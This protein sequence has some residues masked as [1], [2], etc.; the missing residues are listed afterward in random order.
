[1]KKIFVSFLTK[2]KSFYCL[3]KKKKNASTSQFKAYPNYINIKRK[4]KM[5]TICSLKAYKEDFIQ[6]K[7]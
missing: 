3:K 2:S 7:L 6:D 5:L 4:K 1:M